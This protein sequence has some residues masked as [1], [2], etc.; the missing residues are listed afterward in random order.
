MFGNPKEL[1]SYPWLMTHATGNL[2]M[3]SLASKESWSARRSS[4]HTVGSSCSL[5]PLIR[6]LERIPSRRYTL[7]TWFEWSYDFLLVEARLQL[8]A[9]RVKTWSDE[10]QMESSIIFEHG[11]KVVLSQVSMAFMIVVGGI[12]AFHLCHFWYQGIGGIGH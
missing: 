7:P 4:K 3:Y 1:K 8:K 9:C 11:F 2:R 10:Q 6:C 5:A 12:E